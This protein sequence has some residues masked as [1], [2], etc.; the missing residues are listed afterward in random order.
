MLMMALEIAVK[1]LECTVM[2]GLERDCKGPDFADAQLHFTSSST[3]RIID[4]MGL[5][6][7]FKGLPKI[8]HVYEQ[9][10]KIHRWPPCQQVVSLI[11][12][13]S[14]GWRLLFALLK[15]NSG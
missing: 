10:G 9:C 8:V 12:K 7:L 5:I 11:S 2:T 3:D 1:M 14:V 4:E 6:F 15:R 13:N